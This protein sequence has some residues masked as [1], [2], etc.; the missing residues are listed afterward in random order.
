MPDIGEKKV[1]P[2][3]PSHYALTSMLALSFSWLVSPVLAQ[4][5]S[6][7]TDRPLD[8]IVVTA[9]AR[10]EGLQ[11]VPV[12]LSVIDGEGLRESGAF[13]LEQLQSQVP[14]LNLTETGISTNVFIRGI[15][16]GINQGFEQS[17]ALFVD[18][19]HY[20]RAQQMRT[21]FLDLARVEVLRGPQ[22]ILF[23][24]NAVA[25]AL[26]LTT[27][28]PTNEFEAF[29]T[30][31]HELSANASAIEAMISGPLGD[32]VRVR[33][34]G[35]FHQADGYIRNALL[36]SDEPGRE[37]WAIRGTLEADLG[38]D[39]VGSLRLETGRFDVTGRD[40]ELVS[41][42]PATTGPFTGLNY[43]QIL[44]GVFGA[45]PSVLD[46]TQNDVRSASRST[47]TNDHNLAVFTLEWV[48]SENDV[49]SRTAWSRIDY[50]ETCDC[51]GTGANIFVA[52]LQEEYTQLSQEFRL[53]S[54]AGGQFD[55]VTG[56][57]L[58]S[59]EHRYYDQII[60][61]PSSVLVSLINSASPG[62][63]SLL[64]DTQAA[65]QARVDSELWSIF[66][67]VD[68]FFADNWSLQLGGRYTREEREGRRTLSIEAQGGATLPATQS[69]APLVYGN[70][71]GI[72]STNL[73][74]LG[75]PGAGLISSLGALP[76][77]G[78]R[79]EGRFTPD[80]KLLWDVD[81]DLL[82]YA[83][84]TLGFKSGGFD[85]RANNRG[86]SATM[87]EAFEFDD[88]QAESVELGAKLSF[89]D[90]RA[91]LDGAIFRTDFDDL[92]ISIFDG[93]LGFNV[94]NAASARIV[95]LELGGRVALTD[96][97]I[98]SGSAAFT[99]FEF[100]NFRNGQC[101][102]GQAPDVDFDGNGIPE[103]CDYTGNSNQMVSDFQGSLTLDYE[104]PMTSGLSVAGRANVFHTSGYHASP[105]FDPALYQDGYGMINTRIAVFPDHGQWEL[106]I[107]A[108]NLTDERPIIYGNAIPLAGATFGATSHFARFSQARTIHLQFRV[109][110]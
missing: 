37:D 83:S 8:V 68:W 103:L 100:L 52:A 64:A 93:V 30:A 10:E 5:E 24:K 65:R 34:A 21:P 85:F 49:L 78:E 67:Q 1:F 99:D 32:G 33:L 16:S 18:G 74:A 80:I 25:G 41:E 108:N 2:A 50:G 46:N 107:A 9:Q 6:V 47:S 88:E 26:N 42:S 66:G 95:G 38:D 56:V 86:T 51:D 106:A 53:T 76:V 44:V 23:G 102:F 48:G 45:D 72:T 62:S 98:V 29:F 77:S 104:Q 73:D 61:D 13:R 109:R 55:Y 96:R 31:D 39:L 79:N 92:Q 84:W 87:S 15:G 89:L 27:A 110:R 12:S 3:P 54:A 59:S 22:P 58:Q 97:L 7:A 4:Q 14:S 94:G 71:F 17:V 11:D 43:S 101:Y 105:T 35:R 70:V 60:V 69:L 82:L 19:V 63:G 36:N 40:F 57:Y 28:S 20:P 90:G 75:P 91:E 81:D